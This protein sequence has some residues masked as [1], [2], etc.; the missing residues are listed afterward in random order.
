[1][2]TVLTTRF[3]K[4]QSLWTAPQSAGSENRLKN[5]MHISVLLFLRQMERIFIIHLSSLTQQPLSQDKCVSHQLQPSSPIFIEKVAVLMLSK[6][7]SVE[8]VLIY[9]MKCYCIIVLTNYTHGVMNLGVFTR[10]CTSFSAFPQ[11]KKLDLAR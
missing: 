9:V 8:S 4:E 6:P 2:D 3:G 1:M 5:T 10:I 11:S 7:I